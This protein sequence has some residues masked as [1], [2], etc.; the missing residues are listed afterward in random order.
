[1]KKISIIFT[2]LILICTS[3]N[4][5]ESSKEKF[6]ATIGGRFLLDGVAYVGD[7]PSTVHHQ[8]NIPDIRLTGKAFYGDWFMRIDVGFSNS[9]VRLKDSFFQYS[10]KGNIVRIGHILGPFGIDPAVSTYDN[11]FNSPANIHNLTYFGRHLGLTYSRVDKHYYISAGAFY[12][13]NIDNLKTKNQGFN[14]AL[15]AIWRPVNE[16]KRVIQIGVSGVFRQPDADKTTGKRDFLIGGTGVTCC[17]SPLYQN[18]LIDNARNENITGLEFYCSWDKWMIQTE[19]MGMFVPR[20][21]SH[22]F[23][24]HGG[25]LQ[26][27]YL[28]TGSSFSY[29]DTEALPIAPADAKSLQLVF[30]YNF[31]TLNDNKAG[32]FGGLQHD[33]SLGLNY[34]FNKCICSRL[35]WACVMVDENSPLA[36]SMKV[37]NGKLPAIHQLQARLAFWF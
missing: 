16:G 13:D 8:A 18:V 33:I 25:Y 32:L 21:K 36:S 35:N 7:H 12:G 37:T 5:Q 24:G 4:A 17:D 1:M 34:Q 9:Q 31:S 23:V 28:I 15:R 26:L 30:R 20:T 14:T 22:T 3:I 27:G 2:F 11:I 6:K 10:K 29:D 19:Y